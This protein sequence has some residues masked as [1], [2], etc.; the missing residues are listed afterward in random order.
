MVSTSSASTPKFVRVDIIDIP[1]A[2]TVSD[3]SVGTGGVEG[4]KMSSGGGKPTSTFPFD[5]KSSAVSNTGS[6]IAPSEEN[7]SPGR[8]AGF[9]FGSSVGASGSF[10]SESTE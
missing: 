8:E 5:E 4:P 9:C 1:W 6:G 2:N 3:C 7:D 10:H